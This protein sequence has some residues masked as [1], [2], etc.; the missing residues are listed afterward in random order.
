MPTPTTMNR[1]KVLSLVLPGFASVLAVLVSVFKPTGAAESAKAYDLLRNEV[2]ELGKEND[3]LRK[4]L[5]ELRAWMKVWREY[6]D[7]RRIVGEEI[8]SG[9]SRASVV[10]KEDVPPPIPSSRAKVPLRPALPVRADVFG[11]K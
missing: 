4:D 10:L 1:A 7:G 2:V 9:A 6:Q 3:G 5:E 11:G 8:R